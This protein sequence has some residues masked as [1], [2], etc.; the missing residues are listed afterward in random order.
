M[1]TISCYT[2]AQSKKERFPSY[3]G[4]QFRPLIPGDFLGKSEL[5][6]NNGTFKSTMQQRLGYSFGASIRVGLT[7]LISLE[8]G[9]NQVQRK[10]NLAFSYPDSSLSATSTLNILHY[11]IPANALIYIKLSE[12]IYMNSSLGVSFVYA[13]SDVR[14]NIYPSTNGSHMFILE[15]RRN[16]RFA[17]E[18]NANIGFEW[19]TEK[20]GIFYVGGTGKIPFSTIFKIASVYEYQTSTNKIIATDDLV[21]TYLAFD[22]R[23]YFPT[24]KNK[25]TQF[26]PGPIEQ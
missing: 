1:L 4:L 20:N 19:R 8:T 23:Y 3:F 24:V 13:P 14:K 5:Q 22:I 21:G 6:L 12:Q 25:G 7:E 16:N 15:G 11:D 10:Y 18:M 17:F 2:F 26:K 9:I